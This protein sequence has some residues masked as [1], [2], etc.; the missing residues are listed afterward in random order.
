MTAAGENIM[1]RT[2]QAAVASF[3]VVGL[4]APAEAREWKDKTGTYKLEADLVGFDDE[5]VV[6]QRENKELGS[7]PIKDLCEEDQAY[8]KSKEAEQIRANSIDQI[9]T[10]TMAS[11]LK[12]R[13]K[14]VDYADKEITLQ[15]R[16]GKTYVNDQVFGNL[17]GVYQQMLP[18]IVSHLEN[19]ELADGPALETWVRELR[20]FSKTYRLQGVVLELENG[21]EYGVPFFLLSEQDQQVLKPGWEAWLKAHEPDSTEDVDDHSFRLQQLA[22]AYHR[23]QQINQ[24]IAIMNLNM[25]AIQAGIAS[26]WEVTLYPAAGYN[27]PPRWVVV[28]A[29]NSLQATQIALQQNPGYVDGPVRRVSR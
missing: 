27:Y 24:Q 5:N 6:L 19:I 21:D 12:V 17:P 10:W 1:S 25:Q 18:K 4:L 22:A 20:G 2:L 9:Q 29:R 8:L 28:L 11:G 23:D 26:A 3:L 7:C 14:I 16:R 13:G 15:R